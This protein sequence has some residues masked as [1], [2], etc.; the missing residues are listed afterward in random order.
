MIFLAFIIAATYFRLTLL[1][2]L[3][4]RWCHRFY[5]ASQGCISPSRPKLRVCRQ[6]PMYELQEA[7]CCYQNCCSL[8]LSLKP[9]WHVSVTCTGNGSGVVC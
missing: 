4:G 5:V 6:W 8:A 2:V 9:A 7:R 1:N 3:L